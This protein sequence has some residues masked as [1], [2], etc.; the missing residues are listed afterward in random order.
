M[1]AAIAEAMSKRNYEQAQV[2][3]ILASAAMS[4]SEILYQLSGQVYTGECGPVTIRPVAR[5]T[6]TDTRD[7]AALSPL[8][9]FSSW[10]MCSAY[11][12]YTPGVVSHHGCSNPPEIELGAYPVTEI[13]QVLIDGVVIPADEYELRNHRTLIRMRPS[14]SAV[15]TERY[16]WPTCQSGDLPDTQQGTF[17]IT[18]EYG[19][20]PPESGKL[21][22]LKL[23]EYIA[24]PQLG[25][26]TRYP[27]RVKQ[28]T[29][30]GVTTSTTDATD[31]LKSG[32]IGIWEVD[33]FLLAVNP[34][35]NQRQAAVWSPDVGR[36]RRTASPTLPT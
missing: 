15:P 5:P 16:G 3:Q 17:S 28:V 2:D 26:T 25:D 12:S 14:A 10:G 4:A 9:W 35:R 18:Y 7:W 24:L 1:T 21:A 20:P 30:Q 34:K 31:M 23:A 11:G 8:G 29:R 27:K 6:D 33:A 32:S 36:P 19:S 13:V 22:A